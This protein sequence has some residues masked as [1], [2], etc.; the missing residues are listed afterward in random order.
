M[1]DLTYLIILLMWVAGMV[2][3]VGWHKVLALFPPYAI[4]VFV[5]KILLLIGWI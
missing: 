4:Y 2:L 1:K 5:E 3:A